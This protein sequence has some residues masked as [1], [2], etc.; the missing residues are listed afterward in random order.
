[1]WDIDKQVTVK[2]YCISDTNWIYNIH[3][4]HKQKN[5]T[6]KSSFSSQ[7]MFA[8]LR[9]RLMQI[10]W[11]VFTWSQRLLSDSGVV[12]MESS[13]FDR[14]KGRG[15]KRGTPMRGFPGLSFKVAKWLVTILFT[16][17]VQISARAKSNHKGG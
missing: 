4:N 2:L 10:F 13:A 17:I 5:K 9:Q 16:L 11:L 8:F 7:Q 3:K 6:H 12:I 15:E 14:Y 1:M